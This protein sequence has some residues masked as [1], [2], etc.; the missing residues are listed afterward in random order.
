MKINTNEIAQLLK[1]QLAEFQVDLDVAEVGE[2]IMVGD[3]VAR[4]SGLENVMSSE[5]VELPN[6][7]FGMALN[8]EEDNVGLVLF[9]D[10]SLVKEGDL[11]KRTGRIVE[12]PVGDAMLG[13]IVN[14]LGHAMDGKGDIKTTESLPVERKALGV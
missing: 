9:G 2:I 4:A 1:Q 13:R 6:G 8:L 14:P 5:L 12:V 3:G 11:A 10:S 7:V